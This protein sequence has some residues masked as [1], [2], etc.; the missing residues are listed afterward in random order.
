M[1]TMTWRNEITLKD[2]EKRGRK[3][4]TAS[5]LAIRTSCQL[6]KQR[7]DKW[8]TYIFVKQVMRPIL[9]CHHNNDIDYFKQ[10]WNVLP[11]TKIMCKGTVEQCGV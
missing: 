8:C 11:H 1:E 4:S 6:F 5:K 3:R 7:I 2:F 10:K 9:N